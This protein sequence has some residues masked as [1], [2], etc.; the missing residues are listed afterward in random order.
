MSSKLTGMSRTVSRYIAVCP[1]VCPF[2][3]PLD[4]AEP[5]FAEHLRCEAGHPC[6]AFSF[7]MASTCAAA[8]EG[9]DLT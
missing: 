5:S 9:F 3:Q 6:E 7:E 2:G 4:G 1:V 8:L